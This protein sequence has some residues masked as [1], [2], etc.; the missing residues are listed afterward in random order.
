MYVVG[1]RRLFVTQPFQ[2]SPTFTA[3]HLAT[4]DRVFPSDTDVP[5]ARGGT[6]PRLARRV[7]SWTMR[8]WLRS[9]YNHFDG[10]LPGP[11]HADKIQIRR[12][13]SRASMREAGTTPVT[14]TSA[15]NPKPTKWPF[16]RQ[17]TK[18]FHLGY[19]DTS[20]DESHRL[21]KIHEPDG[22]PDTLQ[23]VQHG[24]LTILASY[25]NLGRFTAA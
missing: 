16:F 3:R 4:G 1:L 19:D 25:K 9:I 18:L 24:A 5:H 21:V 14:T 20:I 8:A 17:P 7:P 22:K 13:G 2:I 6:I 12:N 23:Q 15:S 10:Y 11:V